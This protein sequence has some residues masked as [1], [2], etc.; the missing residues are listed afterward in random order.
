MP[1]LW[2]F[3]MEKCLKVDFTEF[4]L[5]PSGT[6]RTESVNLVGPK[7]T[8]TQIKSLSF[9]FLWSLVV[10]VPDSLHEIL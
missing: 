5:K 6:D 4:I 1:I 2:R 10:S 7:L 9:I 8:C 3:A